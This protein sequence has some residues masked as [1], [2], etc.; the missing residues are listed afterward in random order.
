MCN[1]SFHHSNRYILFLAILILLT[2]PGFGLGAASAAIPS[3][4]NINRKIS[5]LLNSLTLEEKVGQLFVVGGNWQEQRSF[6]L[7]AAYHF[8][9][10]CLGSLDVKKMNSDQVKGLT[11]QLQSEALKYNRKIPMFI[12]IDQEGGLV[13]R[14]EK[15]FVTFPSQEEVAM[16]APETLGQVART[17]ARQLSEVGINVNL[18]PV[19][20]VVYNYAGHIARSHRAFG[21]DPQKVTRCAQVYIEKFQEEQI[22]PCVK[23]FPNDGDLKQDPHSFFPINQKSKEELLSTSLVPY[24]QLMKGG[25]IK[26]MLISHAA[27]PALEPD[28]SVPASL[29]KNVI[30]GF[31]R[32]ELGYQGLIV[33]DEMN[34][35]ALGKDGKRPTEEQVCNATVKAVDA[36]A[37]LLLF[38]GFEQNQVAAYQTLLKAYREKKLSLLQLNETIKRILDLKMKLSYLITI[39]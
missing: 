1:K 33:I 21:D 27:V 3:D 37:D 11:R 36:G 8:G 26:M 39:K 28:P 29:S 19:V 22:I 5:K 25:L 6:N 34:M 12:F 9:N 15:G 23:H 2:A 35:R 30:Q 4:K 10:A 7:I 14:L 32:G 38:S 16:K 17:T 20:D 13:N 18:A 31:I 24:L